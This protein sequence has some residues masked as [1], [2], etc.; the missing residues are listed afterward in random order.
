MLSMGQLRTTEL[1]NS[2]FELNLSNIRCKT[3]K[4]KTNKILYNHKI[5]SNKMISNEI[6]I[7][8][9]FDMRCF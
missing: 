6:D 9:Y 3:V 8:S 4:K 5:D 2:A 1:P 7:T